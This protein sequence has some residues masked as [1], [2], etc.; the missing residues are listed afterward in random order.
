MAQRLSKKTLIPATLLATALL[1]THG[2]AQVE[3]FQAS[4]E[5]TTPIIIAETTALN[6]GEISNED[7]T[8]CVI[9]PDLGGASGTGC[10]GGS[11]SAG[12]YSITTGSG[13]LE[14]TVDVATPE[15]NGVT[16]APLW[17][18]GGSDYAAGAPATVST[19]GSLT[20][21]L[22]GTVSTSG[23]PAGGERTWDF[24]IAVTY[25]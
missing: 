18:N 9:D 17:K 3:T 2:M 16:F 25:Q 4:A 1:S 21:D 20:L 11:P 7:G 24:T 22:G 12:S 19:T 15:N 5:V 6:F 23:T 14:I 8:S 10:T 13:T